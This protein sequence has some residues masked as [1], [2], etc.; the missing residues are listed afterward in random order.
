MFVYAVKAAKRKD[1]SEPTLE[2]VKAKRNQT[3]FD[4]NEGGENTGSSDARDGGMVIWTGAAAAF[5][6]TASVTTTVGQ[7]SGTN[8]GT[9]VGEDGGMDVG[10]GGACGGGCAGGA[11]GCGVGVG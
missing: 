2:S 5:A 11:G 3:Y 8:K 4:A 10:G 7:G 1:A 9:E 6:T